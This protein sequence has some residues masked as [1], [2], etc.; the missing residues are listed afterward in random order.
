MGLL[1]QRADLYRSESA[2]GE[3][4]IFVIRSLKDYMSMT[5]LISLKVLLING[6]RSM[7]EKHDLP[8]QIF[9][10]R[11]YDTIFQTI[12]DFLTIPLHGYWSYSNR[13][14]SLD[15]DVTNLKISSFALS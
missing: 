7:E 1:P 3:C 10:F 14:T 2:G 8:N 13:F 9:S 11:N 6:P 5:R 15:V 4:H 12:R